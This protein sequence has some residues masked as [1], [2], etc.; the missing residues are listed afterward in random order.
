QF[1]FALFKKPLL[2]APRDKATRPRNR[3]TAEDEQEGK[4]KAV[5]HAL[6][7]KSRVSVS[8]QHHRTT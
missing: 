3:E 4:R 8:A 7:G 1:S 6:A 2:L 5:R